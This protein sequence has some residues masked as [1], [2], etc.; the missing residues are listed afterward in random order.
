MNFSFSAAKEV[1]LVDLPQLPI[2]LKVV[3]TVIV[4]T[5]LVAVLTAVWR[6]PAILREINPVVTEQLETGVKRFFLGYDQKIGD[7]PAVIFGEAKGI[8][9]RFGDE[10]GVFTKVEAEIEAAK[11]TDANWSYANKKRDGLYLVNALGLNE[12]TTKENE[13]FLQLPL[14]ENVVTK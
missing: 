13:I 8:V 7:S 4:V 5:L 11:R 14:P 3:V 10:K 12:K 1:I 9:R 6:R 2:W